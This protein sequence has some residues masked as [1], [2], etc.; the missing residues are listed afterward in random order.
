MAAETDEIEPPEPEPFYEL[1]YDPD[2]RSF[3]AERWP[4]ATFKDASDWL[5]EGRFEVEIPGVTADE[6]YPLVIREGWSGCCLSFEMAMRLSEKRDDVRRW[7]D[8][9]QALKEADQSGRS[10]GSDG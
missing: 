1:V 6:V 4:Q 3:F 8:G 5:H 9:A 2:A 10:G 7:I